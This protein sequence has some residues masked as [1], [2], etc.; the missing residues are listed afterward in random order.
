[1]KILIILFFFKYILLF[2]ESTVLS[3]TLSADEILLGL[4]VKNRMVGVSGKIVDNEKYSNIVNETVGYK[5]AES[6]LE[7]ILFMKPD[8]VIAG[9]WMGKERIEHLENAGLN[10]FKYKTPRSFDS[11]VELVNAIGSKLN[12]SNRSEILVKNFKKR[13]KNIETKAKDIKNIKT[14]VLY[15]KSGRVYGSDTIF[16]DISKKANF[17]NLASE[18]K[19]KGSTIISKEKLVELNPDIIIVSSYSLEKEDPF[20][21]E[22]LNDRSLQSISA[23]KNREV[24][25]VKGKYMMT[26]SHHMIKALEDI[27]K[28]VYPNFEKGEEN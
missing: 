10:V 9:D 27:F 8:L 14:A 22:L 2:G 26:S 1:M 4:G 11:L 23:I 18:N 5:R 17:K 21:E 13:V 25:P 7:N 19:I 24:F 20:I 15:S 28:I 12:V 3:L 16:D 6:N